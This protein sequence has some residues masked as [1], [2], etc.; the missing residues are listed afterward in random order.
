[1]SKRHKSDLLVS[2]Q[3]HHRQAFELY[4]SQ[5][6]KHSY[7][8]V[9]KAV[10]V[11]ASAVKLW[12]RSFGWGERIR[13]QVASEVTARASR[14]LNSKAENIER[15]LKIVRA[16]LHRT[17]REISQGRVKSQIGDL[18]RLIRLEDHL[19][20]QKPEDETESAEE[21]A[22]YQR[23]AMEVG[24][25]VIARRPAFRAVLREYLDDKEKWLRENQGS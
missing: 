17:A 16:A 24:A 10:G 22:Q 21:V 5:G 11:S 13:Q 14:V 19:V 2:E 9:A 15:N 1:M 6:V 4:R 20:D 25:E 3:E 8:V 7:A 23:R 18:E 12:S